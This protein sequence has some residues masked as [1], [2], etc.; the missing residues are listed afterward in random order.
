MHKSGACTCAGREHAHAQVDCAL[1]AHGFDLGVAPRPLLA[2]C[3]LL[4]ATCY[5]LLPTCLVWHLVLNERRPAA[6]ATATRAASTTHAL[7]AA[8]ASTATAS[9]R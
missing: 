8:A 1:H 2:T 7:S 3:Y 9:V 5:L 4:L 6:T